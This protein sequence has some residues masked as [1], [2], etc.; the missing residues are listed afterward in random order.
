MKLKIYFFALFISVVSYLSWP[1]GQSTAKTAENTDVKK[2]L[3]AEELYLKEGNY[4]RA[5]Q[6]YLELYKKYPQNFA[7]LYN[8]GNCY[9]QLGEYPLALLFYK[10]AKRLRPANF[11]LLHNLQ[12]T[13]QR[14]ELTP[15]DTKLREKLFFW[16]Y[17]LNL[18]QLFWGMTAL[19]T[20]FLLSLG[21][22]L[23]QRNRNSLLRWLSISLG[24]FAVTAISSF[25]TKYYAEKIEKVG[26]VTE[27]NAKLRSG[28]GHYFEEIKTLPPGTEIEIIEKIKVKK[29]EKVQTWCKVRARISGE[30]KKTIGWLPKEA[31]QEL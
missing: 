19:L 31:F 7:L 22:T 27:Q 4:S 29:G 26:I 1:A 6:L 8:I 17:L 9:F 25:G 12:L 13:Y 24:I 21:F 10:R 20:L 23:Y 11:D 3:R 30:T 28:Y 14:L 5:L 2:Y 16:Y 15:P 18:E